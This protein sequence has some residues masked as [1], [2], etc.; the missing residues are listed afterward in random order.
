M[1]LMILSSCSGKKHNFYVHNKDTQA[2]DSLHIFVGDKTYLIEDLQSQ[3]SKS[4][5][6]SQLGGHKLALQADTGKVMNL[7]IR[8]S[9]PFRGTI[10]SIITKERIISSGTYS[11]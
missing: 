5:K 10:K 1:L 3:K 7:G 6:I 4:L 2:I 11:N 8:I 9:P